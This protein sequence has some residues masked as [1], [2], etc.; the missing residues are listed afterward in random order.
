MKRVASLAFLSC[1]SKKPSRLQW[2]T[3]QTRPSSSKPLLEAM[4]L[5]EQT[6]S[7]KRKWFSLFFSPEPLFCDM[8]SF[9]RIHEILYLFF[10]TNSWFL[11]SPWNID[12]VGQSSLQQNRLSCTLTPSDWGAH[13]ASAHQCSS[14]L[15]SQSVPPQSGPWCP[16]QTC[17]SC[18]MQRKQRSMGYWAQLLAINHLQCCWQHGFMLRLHENA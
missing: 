8:I 18:S 10:S 13:A 17:H 7:L 14:P 5:L 11:S 4:S 2:Q 16:S 9:S 6:L 15:Q 12:S 3:L 1:N